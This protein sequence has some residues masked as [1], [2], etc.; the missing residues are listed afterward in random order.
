M[1]PAEMRASGGAPLSVAF[2]R[3]KDGKMSRPVQGIDLC[4]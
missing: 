2:V 3:F 1:N 4:R